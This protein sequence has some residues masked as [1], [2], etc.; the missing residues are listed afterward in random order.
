[1][2]SF[3][4][5]TVLDVPVSDLFLVSLLAVGN[6]V[7]AHRNG[8]QEKATITHVLSQLYAIVSKMCFYG[9]VIINLISL[10]FLDFEGRQIPE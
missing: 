9:S 8:F 2:I 5:G 4:D 10:F 3:D 1:M 6:D 7:M